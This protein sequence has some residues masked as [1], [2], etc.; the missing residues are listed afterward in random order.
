MSTNTVANNSASSSS[1]AAPQL[2][3][4]AVQ[5]ANAVTASGT[6]KKKKAKF[7][8]VEGHSKAWN[9]AEYLASGHVGR[10]SANDSGVFKWTGTHWA[11]INEKTGAKISGDFMHDLFPDKASNS[12]KKDAWLYACDRV[13]SQHP[14]PKPSGQIIVP[15][16]NAYVHVSKAGG[17]TVQQ[18]D[19]R[20]GLTHVINATVG[21]HHGHTHNP[22]PVPPQS[23]FGRFLDSAL[24]DVDVRALIQEQCAL[25]LMPGPHQ[26]A[27]WW[28]G[29]GGNGKGVMTSIL[30]AF[31]QNTAQIWLD[32][33]RDPTRLAPVVNASLLITPEV[34]R[35]R[36]HEEQW[37][38]LTGGDPL[39][40]KLLYKDLVEF[41]NRAVHFISSNDKPFVTD[42]SDAVYRRLCFVEWTQAVGSYQKDDKL[43]EKI[44]ASEAHIVLDWML[45]GLQRVVARGGFMPEA[46]WPESIRNLKSMIRATND[47]VGA[48]ADACN[49]MGVEA[50]GKMTPKTAIY[51]S[52]EQW[53]RDDGRLPL[54]DNIFWRKV[55]NVPRFRAYQATTA[56][57][58]T[59]RF[60]DKQVNAVRLRLDASTTTKTDQVSELRWPRDIY[61]SGTGTIDF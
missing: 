59:M 61:V 16:L 11:A 49:V 20:E 25:T 8:L 53:C 33:L 43:V 46:Q 4:T 23:M 36:W 42:I 34:S 5:A 21:T 14:L 29:T 15:C 9:F 38:A 12:G 2:P 7:Q 24:A 6:F 39:M 41:V 37:K 22:Q 44:M 54:A 60:N 32:D 10:F 1:T 31:H 19:P 48:W 45:E 35:G 47:C 56:R 58:Y 18:A 28:F 26:I 13:A 51:A 57:G 30:K 50:N 40:A 52:Y 27:F 55:W 17:I 3:K